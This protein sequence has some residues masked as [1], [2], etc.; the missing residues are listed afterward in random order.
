MKCLSISTVRCCLVLSLAA[1]PGMVG[2]KTMSGWKMPSMF[3]SREP[4]ADKLAGRTATPPS[5]ADKYSPTTLA[6]KNSTGATSPTTGGLAY[7][8]TTPTGAVSNTASPG[9][10]GQ[11]NG[12]PTGRY[13]TNPDSTTKPN[14]SNSLVSAPNNGIPTGSNFG[15]INPPSTSSG[16][17]S[18]TGALSPYGGTY[19]GVTPPASTAPN[20]NQVETFGMPNNAIGGTTSGIPDITA[21]SLPSYPSIPNQPTTGGF[22]PAAP[23]YSPNNQP[24]ASASATVAS[25][26]VPAVSAYQSTTPGGNYAPGTTGRANNYNFGTQPS[27]P[28]G[29]NSRPLPPN[30]ASGE[31]LLIR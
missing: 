2:C 27:S 28:T 21:N 31:Q 1:L 22:A 19:S 13:T 12:Y 9:L 25:P 26:S 10:A 24:I 30:T 18:Q 11:A 6:N 7:G 5:P 16:A 8:N 3:A 23:A 20:L 29:T 14:G 15:G 17:A 4:D